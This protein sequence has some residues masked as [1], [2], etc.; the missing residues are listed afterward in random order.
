MWKNIVR[1]YTDPNRATFGGD[2][3]GEFKYLGGVLVFG[4]NDTGIVFQQHE[5]SMGDV[6]DHAAILEA[7]STFAS[8]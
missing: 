7:I 5:Q 2:S 3:T 8:N 1:L 6:L 4:P